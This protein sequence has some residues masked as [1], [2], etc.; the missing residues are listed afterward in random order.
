MELQRR[1]I[2]RLIKEAQMDKDPYSTCTR[3]VWQSSATAEKMHKAGMVISKN[4]YQH[5]YAVIIVSVE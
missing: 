2:G 3:V 1:K 5:P 4:S